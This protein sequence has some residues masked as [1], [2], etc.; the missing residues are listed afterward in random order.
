MSENGPNIYA[1]VSNTEV[2]VALNKLKESLGWKILCHFLQTNA[3][4]TTAQI[5]LNRLPTMDALL[6]QEFDKGRLSGMSYA[7]SLPDILIDNINDSKE[8][9]EDDESDDA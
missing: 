2:R 4:S 9:G 3:D 5:I 7:Q 1:D 8:T 6:G